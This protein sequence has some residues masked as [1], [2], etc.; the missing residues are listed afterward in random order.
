[1]TV[2][3]DDDNERERVRRRHRCTCTWLGEGAVLLHKITVDWIE[4]IT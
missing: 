2:G 4:V 3:R 1:M